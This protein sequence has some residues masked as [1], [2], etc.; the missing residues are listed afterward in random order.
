MS[1]AIDYRLCS[2]SAICICDAITTVNTRN[3]DIDDRR[4]VHDSENPYMANDTMVIV[5]ASLPSLS[6]T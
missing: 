5:P 6:V 3:I 1:M 4:S 2:E